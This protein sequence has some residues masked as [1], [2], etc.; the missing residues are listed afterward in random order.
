[1]AEL[2]FRPE[3][4]WP[5]KCPTE[6]ALGLEFTPALAMSLSLFLR[7]KTNILSVL[8]TR[9][10]RNALERQAEAGRSVLIWRV[11]LG[12]S[13]SLVTQP[14]GPG[15]SRT[16]TGTEVVLA[17]QRVPSPASGGSGQPGATG[18]PQG[19]SACQGGRLLVTQ[20]VPT[21]VAPRQQRVNLLSVGKASRT[22]LPAR[23]CSGLGSSETETSG[24]PGPA[25]SHGILPGFTFYGEAREGWAERGVQPVQGRRR[26][27]RD[28]SPPPRSH[29]APTPE[30]CSRP[31]GKH[32]G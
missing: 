11:G 18:P 30:T 27:D 12:P 23:V 5:E 2:V 26:G 8:R 17:G 31:G 3:S 1:M 21:W 10:N 7:K 32:V 29:P 6:N 28:P 19:L 20:P 15:Q 4:V 16:G 25:S 22:L 24:A 13:L 9:W 14:G